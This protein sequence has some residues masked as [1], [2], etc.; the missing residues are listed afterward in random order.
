MMTDTSI[1]TLRLKQG[2]ERVIAHGHPW[3]FSDAEDVKQRST[4]D[5]GLT[6]IMEHG[7]RFMVDITQSQKTGFYLD[8]RDNRKAVSEWCRD[9]R[10][11]GAY[12]YTGAVRFTRKKKA[13]GMR[14]YKDINRLAML[15]LS[16]GGLV[17]TFSCSELISL[18]DFETAIEWAARDA[19]RT[20]QQ[21]GRFTQPPDHPVRVGFPENEYLKGVLCRVL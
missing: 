20:V 9:R 10:V 14:A 15:L 3:I 2:R 11:L 12:C 16:P 13:K 7:L 18:S 1:P 8:Q 5:G 6:E 19:G 21:I 4:M 17:A